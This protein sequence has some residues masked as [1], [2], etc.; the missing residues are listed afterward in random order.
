MIFPNQKKEAE[1]SVIPFQ[2]KNKVEQCGTICQD[3][4]IYVLRVYCGLW[5]VLGVSGPHIKL[6]YALK[7]PVIY[8]IS[9][10]WLP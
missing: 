4:W 7:L 8:R 2:M 3:I 10:V 9:D 5:N 6:W 1:G